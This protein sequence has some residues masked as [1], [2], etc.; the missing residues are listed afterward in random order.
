MRS[1]GTFYFVRDRQSERLRLDANG[2]VTGQM[3]TLPY[4][5]DFGESGPQEKHHFTSYEG[6]VEVGLDS[7]VL[8]LARAN[9]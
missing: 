5:E 7:H 8:R 1:A 3:G 2:N 4:D 9:C 6:D